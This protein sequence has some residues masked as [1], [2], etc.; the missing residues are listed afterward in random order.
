[1]PLMPPIP[2]CILLPSSMNFNIFG[3]RNPKDV[4]QWLEEPLSTHIRTGDLNLS[5]LLIVAFL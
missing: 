4:F 5:I 1:M 2:K 3:E